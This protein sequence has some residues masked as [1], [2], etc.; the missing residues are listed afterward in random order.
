MKQQGIRFRP[1][2]QGINSDKKKRPPRPRR[3]LRNLAAKRVLLKNFVQT[4]GQL[5]GEIAAGIQPANWFSMY[6][7]LLVENDNRRLLI[8][9]K[10]LRDLA[11]RIAQHSDFQTI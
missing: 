4:R 1:D 10:L 7:A 6:I 9:A 2:E 8:D 5:V 11:V 3:P